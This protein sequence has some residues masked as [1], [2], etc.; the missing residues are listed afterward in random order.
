MQ[1]KLKFLGAANNVTGSS[2]MLEFNGTRLLID[3]GLYQERA[4][5]HRNW[6]HFSFQPSS[7]DAV[8]LTHAH[9]D[10]C[11]LIPKLVREGFRGKIYCNTATSAIAQIILLD[12]AH[13]QEED[14]KFK[15]RRHR[16]EKKKGPFP[17]EP[18]YTQEDAQASF[19]FFEPVN[20][21]EPIQLAEGVRAVFCDAG[22]VLG[23]S[24]I[25]ITLTQ[26]GES[27]TVLFS[28]D[29]G[30]WDKP[31][32]ED[33][34]V[35][36]HIDYVIVESTY[37]D[38]VHKESADIGESLAEIVNS[39]YKAGGN[40]IVPSFALQR[41]QEILYHMNVLLMENKIPHLLVFLDSPM[42]AKITE[43]F[44]QNTELFDREM[45]Q[46]IRQQ[47]S[48]FNFPGFTMTQSTDE[49]KAL[50]HVSGT[51]MIIAGS[52]M[53]TGGRIKHHLVSNITRAQSTILFVGYQASGTLGRRIV[54]GAKRVRIL[55]QY[56][57]VRAR[58]AQIHGF[59]AH[60]DRN[61]LLHWMSSLKT[62]PRRVFIV[63]GEPKSSRELSRFLKQ[64][65]GWKI[66]MPTYQSE[67]ILD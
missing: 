18:L 62:P 27:R 6:E 9:V 61:E 7:V 24:M 8:L 2:F 40:I 28:G 10:H 15:G 64:N 29:V 12:A 31:I 58:I 47:K 41:S 67:K 39:T 32:L 1:I 36:E 21:L 52:G 37:G 42:A 16:R 65:T 17:E 3:C 5:K 30:R 53:C 19:P 59:S 46:L 66:T 23:S 60:A 35:F 45:S 54:E 4:L 14:A 56:Y 43:V 51:T 33:P 48:P 38:R 26:Q 34:S 63:H 50:N 20:Y 25:K 49:S 57:P 55:G 44:K 13:L 11:G 22:H